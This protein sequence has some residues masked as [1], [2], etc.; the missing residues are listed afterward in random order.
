MIEISVS[1]NVLLSILGT[2]F[3]GFLLLKHFLKIALLPSVEELG[4]DCDLLL[5]HM[6]LSE[7]YFCLLSLEASFFEVMDFKKCPCVWMSF[8]TAPLTL[9]LRPPS[10][11]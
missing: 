9:Y 7:M 6:S 3:V 4:S 11:F 8:Y 1:S 2:P 10:N 5:T